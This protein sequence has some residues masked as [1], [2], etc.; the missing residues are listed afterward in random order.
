M[1]KPLI[2]ALAAASLLTVPALSTTAGASDQTIGSKKV[3]SASAKAGVAACHA[4]VRTKGAKPDATSTY[5]SGYTP[6]DL[7]SAYNLSGATGTATVA[8][9]DAYNNPNAAADL[10]AYRS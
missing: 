6:A 8:I 5:Q 2:V 9:V 10:A 1:R 3:C 7:I 4:Q